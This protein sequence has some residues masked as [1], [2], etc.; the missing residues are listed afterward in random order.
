MKQ[1]HGWWKIT[2]SKF[3][4][5]RNAIKC[6]M[7]SNIFKM[8][9]FQRY[10]SKSHYC[11][12]GDLLAS[13]VMWGPFQ[14]THQACRQDWLIGYC[15]DTAILNQPKSMEWDVLQHHLYPTHKNCIWLQT[16]RK[17]YSRLWA[18]IKYRYYNNRRI[19]KSLDL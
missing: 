12:I 9:K 17:F 11:V 19:L 10:V 3:D 14:K 16:L 6:L 15:T 1:V 13:E 18:D 2:R 8:T 7:I 5:H 4:V